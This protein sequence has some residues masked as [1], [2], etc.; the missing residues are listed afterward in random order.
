VVEA[1]PKAKSL[2]LVGTPL[3]PQLS[4]TIASVPDDVVVV[5]SLP[6]PAEL[7]GPVGMQP[8]PASLARVYVE[9]GERE[10]AA[11][12]DSPVFLLASG[13]DVVAPPEC[14]RLPSK[15]WTD[16]SFMRLDE[17]SFSQNRHGDLL[18]DKTVMRKIRKI[19]DR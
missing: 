1:N 5:D 9:L 10:A 17:F 19:L 2:V 4:P 8:Y 12:P 13:A 18:T 14:V 3:G 6:W 16:R 15:E 7:L 11:D